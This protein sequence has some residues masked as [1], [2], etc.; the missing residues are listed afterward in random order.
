VYLNATYNAA[1]STYSPQTTPGGKYSVQPYP[2]GAF[3]GHGQAYAL[4]AIQMERRLE[5]GMEGQRFF[6]LARWDNGTGTMATTLNAYV[7]VEKNRT[8]FYRVN[9]TATFTKGVNECFAIP[10]NEIQAENA[11]GKVY[12]QQNPGYQ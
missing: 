5:L 8:G 10:L 1:N 2:A 9:N 12:L 4:N 11:T 3:S 7:A 6:D